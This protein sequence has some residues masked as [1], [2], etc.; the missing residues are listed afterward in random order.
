[1]Q[2][3][4]TKMIKYRPFSM[5][6]KKTDEAQGLLPFAPLQVDRD[7]PAGMGVL[8]DGTPFLTQRGLADLCGV[9][10]AHI[11]TISRDW[12]LDQPRIATIKRLLSENGIFVNSPHIPVLDGAR[13][14]YA[15]PAEICSAILEY[16]AF[17]AP[18][19]Q[20]E[21]VRWIRRLVNKSLRDF[22]YQA[23]GFK[24][25]SV[26]PLVWQQFQDRVV[27]NHNSVP[28][29]YF[30]IWK[31]L[32]DLIVTLIRAGAN[33]GPE[34]VPD[35]SVGVHWA[36][37]WTDNDLARKF[38]ERRR[39]AHNYP[40]YFPQAE[41]NPQE[42]NCYPNSALAEFRRWMEEEYLVLKLPKYLKDSER[43]GKV[44]MQISQHA[45]GA[46]AQRQLPRTS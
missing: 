27:L 37:H 42:P 39:Y 33:V 8:S 1:M 25:E 3:T 34:F 32:A 41:S 30:S 13:T 29:G 26:I 4:M 38:G 46:I 10:N 40:H 35:V 18:Q 17:E 36:K 20:P 7:V 14:V 31:E 21:A 43:K 6:G 28:L 2:V 45:L 44:S 23:V 5:A 24:P 16:Y 22:I 11:G 15:Y 19:Q 12:N 9:E